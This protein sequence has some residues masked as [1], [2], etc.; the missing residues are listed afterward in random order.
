MEGRFFTWCLLL[1]ATLSV[2]GGYVWFLYQFDL[3]EWQM[4]AALVPLLLIIRFVI[5]RFLGKRK[6]PE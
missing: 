3:N 4:F 2:F 1:A 5:Q 6:P